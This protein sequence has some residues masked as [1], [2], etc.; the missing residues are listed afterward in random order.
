MTF[1]AKKA[2]GV[3]GMKNLSKRETDPKK[4]RA[5]LQLSDGSLVDDT[6]IVQQNLDNDY[7][8]GLANFGAQLKNSDPKDD[9]REPAEDEVKQVMDVCDGC[10]EE[11]FERAL[12]MG[13]RNV[14]K[15]LYSGAIHT[16]AVPACKAF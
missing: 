8:S 12:V 11:P 16:P 6:F 3:F 1:V 13:W 9:E 10:A 7:F 14:P 15:K 2:D 5:L 4:K